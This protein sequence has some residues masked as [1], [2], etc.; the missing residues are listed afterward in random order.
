[1]AQQC[2]SGSMN[3]PPHCGETSLAVPEPLRIR[4]ITACTTFFHQQ[5]GMLNS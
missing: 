2:G 4:R 5:N 3:G 1:M